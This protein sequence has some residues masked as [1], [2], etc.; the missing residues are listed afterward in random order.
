MHLK[1]WIKVVHVLDTIYWALFAEMIILAQNW[2]LVGT[3]YG[4]NNDLKNFVL[5]FTQ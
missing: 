2:H 5:F 1:I 4:I 3:R